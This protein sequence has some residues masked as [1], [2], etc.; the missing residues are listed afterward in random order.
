MLT[1]ERLRL[2]G[3]EVLTLLTTLERAAV[4]LEIFHADGREGVGRV[5]LCFVVVD[6][7]DWHRLV[8]DMRL[9]G[10][11]VDDWLNRLMHVMMYVLAGNGSLGAVRLL[12]F[13]AGLGV[14]VLL[15]FGVKTALQICILGVVERFA[16]YRKFGVVMLLR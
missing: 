4:L 13:D 1:G 8:H 5:M 16:F 9:D 6:L 3:E 12:A 15:A 2:T 11:L 14:V 10:L 7:V